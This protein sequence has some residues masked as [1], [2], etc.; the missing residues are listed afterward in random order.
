MNTT[1]ILPTLSG[2][3]KKLACIPFKICLSLLYNKDFS[4]SLAPLPLQN[5]H[6]KSL[7]V[8]GNKLT[9]LWDHSCRDAATDIN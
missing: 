2:G 4:L 3:K 5:T 6:Q 8:Q 7:R 1:G 9:P